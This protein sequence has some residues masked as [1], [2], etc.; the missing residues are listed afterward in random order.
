LKTLILGIQVRNRQ[1]SKERQGRE[2]IVNKHETA[3]C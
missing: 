1:E 2:V 3:G